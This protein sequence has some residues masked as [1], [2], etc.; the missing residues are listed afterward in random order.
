MQ[1][2]VRIDGIVGVTAPDDES[3]AAS[4]RDALAMALRYAIQ[5]IRAVERHRELR[6]V[7]ALGLAGDWRDLR[8]RSGERRELEVRDVALANEGF[9]PGPE[10]R[11]ERHRRR[12]RNHERAPHTSALAG[13]FWAPGPVEAGPSPMTSPKWRAG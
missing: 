11:V 5:Q 1:G 2:D 13:E 10:W 3:L 7:D 9:D 8:R 4:L 12:R 6:A